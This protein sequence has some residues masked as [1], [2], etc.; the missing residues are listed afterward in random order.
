MDDRISVIIPCY[1][2]GHFLPDAIDSVLQQTYS[3]WECI[4]VDDGSSDNTSEIGNNFTKKD[5]RF[6]YVYKSNG[7]LSSARNKGLELA[8]GKWIQ[9]LDADD[10]L[11]PAKFYRQLQPMTVNKHITGIVIYSDYAF[12]KRGNIFE[13][14]NRTMPI[15]FKSGNY[16]EELIA[17]WETDLVIPCHCFLFSSDLFLKNGIRFDET[18]PNHEDFDCWLRV[19]S[20]LPEVMF[21]NEILCSY[22]LSDDS[23]S[24]NM[25]LMGDGFLQVLDKH[26]QIKS[27]PDEIHSSLKIKRLDV[28]QRYKRFDLMTVNEKF[29]S[30]RILREYYCNRVIDKFKQK[31]K[32]ILR[33]SK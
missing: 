19:F 22:R 25:K 10:V 2:Q 1:N 3:N 23:M 27:Y 8:S 4:I 15:E 20:K 5:N 14:E 7:G 28:L 12:G 33:G 26:L 24:S 17:R 18:L 29:A 16:F 31:Q 13:I 30:R 6:K 32:N 21:I 11:E 9:F